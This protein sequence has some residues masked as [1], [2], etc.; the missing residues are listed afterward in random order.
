M[1][2]V[3]P[4]QKAGLSGT[5]QA[6]ADI[7]PDQRAQFIEAQLQALQLS[8]S[9]VAEKVGVSVGMVWQWASG[10]TAVSAKKA[11]PLAD[12]LGCEPWQVSQAFEEI[13]GQVSAQM[14][15]HAVCRA[16]KLYEGVIEGLG[17]AA[18]R[19]AF[20]TKAKLFLSMYEMCIR[21]GA[22]LSS[23]REIAQAVA[24]L[25]LNAKDLADNIN[26]SPSFEE[27]SPT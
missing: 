19:V 7:Q 4:D 20:D 27:G 22:G 12:V 10:K 26:A 5:V 14:N 18:A 17:T 15:P 9:D 1:I 23:E 6:Q 8:H 24:E 2:G 25:L 13:M 16:L 21:K 11:R 3:L